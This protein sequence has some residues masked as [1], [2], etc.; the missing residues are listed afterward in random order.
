MNNT[1]DFVTEIAST[2]N[3]N[4]K[5]IKFLSDK[6]LLTGS[7][8]LKYQIFKTNNL[9]SKSDSNYKIYKKI[10]ITF[11]NLEKLIK[12]Y[13]HK[14][15][16][17]LEPFDEESYEFCKKFKKKI[18]IKISTSETDNIEL[19][20]DSLKHFK[21]IFINLSGYKLKQI[22]TII[23]FFEKKKYKKKIVIMYGFQSYPTNPKDLRFDLFKYFKLKKFKYGY[24]DHSIHGISK[25]LL[26]TTF[27]AIKLGCSFIEK[28]ICKDISKKPHDYI[29]A[30]EPI[31]L[32]VFIKRINNIKK[33]PSV[34]NKNKNKMSYAENIYSKT[35]HKQAFS[36]KDIKK[37]SLVKLQDLNFLRTKYSN[38]L[39]RL[40]VF[41]I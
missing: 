37:G 19:I 33:I 6:H 34:L 29:S 12:K 22:K 23:N 15:K 7:K 11:K 8:Y 13:S 21:K 41:Q 17:I 3:G 24:A 25:D 20:K 36:K 16:L 35:F 31:D 39:T 4:F 28:H 5:T 10:E 2:H 1:I 38:G 32:A 40:E 18:L 27:Q 26:Q 30:L 9:Y 14:T